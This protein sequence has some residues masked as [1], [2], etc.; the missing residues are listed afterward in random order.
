[1]KTIIF[2]L[3]IAVTIPLNAQVS[4]EKLDEIIGQL[5]LDEKVYLVVGTGM[6]IPGFMTKEEGPQAIVGTTKDKVPG[7]AGT[8]YPIKKFDFPAVVLADGPAGVRIDPKRE[9]QPDKTF[10]ATAFP[11]ASSLASSWDVD[12][13]NEVGKAF[14]NEAKAY[15]VDF[16]LGPALNIHRNPL[17]GRNFEYYSE[18]PVLAG[19][20]TVGFVNGIQSEGVGATIKHFVANNSETNRTQLNTVVS[21]RALREIYLKG[22]EIAV[23]ESQ[24]WSVM[25][26]YNK[27]NG[28]YASENEDLL[29]KILRDEWHFKGF[30]MTDW[31]GGMDPVAQMKAGNDLI[32]PGRKDQLNAILEAA[33][34]GNLD[35]SIL[36]R[37]IKYILRQYYK[38]LTFNK[39]TVTNAPD[40]EA[41]K[42]VAR[43]AA[44]ESMVLLK[45]NDAL[46]IKV[47][48]KVALFGNMSFET[49][50]GGTGSGDV[51]KAYMISIYEGLKNAG[52]AL[53]SDLIL[54]YETYIK[55]EKA[56][57]PPK[58][59]FFEK[60]VLIPEKSWTV[61]NLKSYA[62]NNDIAIFTLGRTS[63]EF[64]DRSV[65]GDFNLTADELS[66]INA[67]SDV[68]HSQNKKFV[69][70]LNIGGVIETNSWKN[71]ADA[72]LLTWQS[73][74]ET[75][76]AVADLISGKVTPSGKLAVTFPIDISNIA[77]SKNF[78]GKVLNPD[79]KP[80]ASVFG[81]VPAEEVYEEGIYVGYRYFDSF[82][83]DVSFPF[84]FGLSYTD[85]EYSNL[86]VSNENDIV[87]VEFSIKNTGKV[88]G[89]EI[90]EL[91][92]KSPLGNLEKPEKELK[93]FAKTKLLKKGESQ[94][95]TLKVNVSDLGYYDTK[96]NSWKLDAGNYTFIVGSSSKAQRFS[97]NI[98]LD[99]K[100]IETTEDLLKPQVEI[101]ELSKQKIID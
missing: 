40:F 84:G 36:D 85:F 72:I 55:E 47:N 23:K 21:E 89:K 94:N 56:K 90:V 12:V 63:G 3:F 14:G 74:Q 80:N 65:D 25:S 26:S 58:R 43:T 100:V 54:E 45:N 66:T 8:S 41:N 49:I 76:N 48:T 86:K 98:Q 82:N 81:N 73:G 17:G 50:A 101:N 70:L 92:V 79:A 33:K 32:M 61:E 88:Q 20:L 1:M 9:N 16:L 95:I 53:D 67:I 28:T 22:F 29:T 2:L 46:P 51:N 30:V 99:E 7:A 15:G 83:V 37:N 87:T 91:Y 78:P 6:E 39:E 13:L 64:Q 62:E 57:I 60:D 4:D 35:E 96:T 52:F 31:F 97:E 77:S 11:T 27:I 44:T 34:S 18:D 19:K 5:S 10:Y 68:F 59:M 71:N 69:I 38:T 93:A 75:G 24:P 42:V